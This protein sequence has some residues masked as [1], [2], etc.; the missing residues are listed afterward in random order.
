AKDDPAP[1]GA[2]VEVRG[3]VQPMQEMFQSLALGLAV[4]VAAIFLLLTAYFQSPRLAITVVST[5]PVVVAGVV[6]A[7]L[8]T[9][10]TL[11]IQSFMGA[12][13]AIGV[14]VANAILL[15][16]F[17]ERARLAGQAPLEAALDGAKH[18]LR[19]IL[20]TTCAMVAGM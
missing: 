16:T 12:I 3:Q 5:V 1:R 17:A 4:A 13:M 11:N 18:R 7:L 14:S 15:V 8:A 19:P 9:R 6:L 20:M 2:D 10:T